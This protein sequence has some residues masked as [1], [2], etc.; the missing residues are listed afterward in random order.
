MRGRKPKSAA[1]KLLRGTFRKDRPTREDLQ[2]PPRDL[3]S[4]PEWI[5]GKALWAWRHF[6]THLASKGRRTVDGRHRKKLELLCKTYEIWRDAV[7]EVDRNGQITILHN[8]RG[9]EVNACKNPSVAIALAAA[10]E[11]RLLL[12]SF[13][14]IGALAGAVDSEDEEKDHLGELI[15]RGK[16]R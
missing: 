14:G 3:G 13:D 6:A 1:S 2:P 5:K 11:C 12:A 8:T 7:A 9:D 16:A 4:P 10:K 15:G